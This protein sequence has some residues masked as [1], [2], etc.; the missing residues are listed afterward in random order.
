MFNR[1]MKRGAP[2]STAFRR[3]P[4]RSR[5]PAFTQPETPPP[6]AQNRDKAMAEA[7]AKMDAGQMSRDNLMNMQQAGSLT[8]EDMNRLQQQMDV[9]TQGGFKAG[10]KV[11]SASKR[12]DGIAQRGKTKGRYI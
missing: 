4:S 8:P 2:V 6:S 9:Q 11:G 3:A 10:G 5:S 7:Q 1:I 12:A